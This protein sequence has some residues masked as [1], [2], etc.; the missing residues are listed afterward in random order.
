MRREKRKLLESVRC[1]AIGLRCDTLRAF[2]WE[3]IIHIAMHEKY[4]QHKNVPY[5]HEIG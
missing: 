4:N 5:V 2:Q 1:D 3:R